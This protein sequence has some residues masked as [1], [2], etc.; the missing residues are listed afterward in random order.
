MAVKVEKAKENDVEFLAKMILQSSRADKKIG[1]FDYLFDTSDDTLIIE[2]LQQL[3]LN[4]NQCYCHYKNFLI[5]QVEGEAVGTLCSYEPRVA[6]NDKF[7]NALKE[8]G[9]DE[10]VLQR[11]ETLGVCEFDINKRTLMFDFLEEVEGYID[12]G[13]LK[14]LMQKSLLDARLKGYRVAQTIV[15]IG[16]LESL[17]FYEKLGFVQK[18]KKECEVYKEIFG[19][20]GVMLLALEF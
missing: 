4:P 17:L 3:I 6:T 5:A 12:V 7:V 18:E 14:Q 8:I 10:D 16:S 20:V 9:C 19:R 11:L 1:L 2:K 13:I 15:E